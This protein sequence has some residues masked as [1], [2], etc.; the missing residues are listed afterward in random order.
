MKERLI[1]EDAKNKL[2]IQEYI[3]NLLRNENCSQI[4]VRRTPLGT[5]IVIYTTTPGI[6]IGSN[7]SGINK[8]RDLLKEKF[9]LENTQIDIQKIQ[10][11]LLD[12]KFVAKRLAELIEKGYNFKKLGNIY[13]QKIMNAGAIGCEIVFAG[14][15]SG[16]KSRTERFKQGYLIKSGH[17]TEVY[18][19][20][21]SATA[22]P[23]LGIINV[24]VSIIVAHPERI[25]KEKLEN[26][27][28]SKEKKEVKEKTDNK[29]NNSKEVESKEA[30]PKE[31]KTKEVKSKEVESKEAKP[32]EV[33]SKEDKTN[34]KEKKKEDKNDV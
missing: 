28:S 11:P 10:N 8:L 32:K 6:I 17:P 20:K 13:K 31:D 27:M 33:K 12:S 24:R 23:K 15:L 14:K 34:V 9:N 26:L 29:K 21:A 19:S 1:I 5:R 22:I 25:L 16:E 4:D 3:M 30:K 2:Q 18:V 7:G